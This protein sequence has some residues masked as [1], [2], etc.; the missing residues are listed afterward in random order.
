MKGEIEVS[1]IYKGVKV[2]EEVIPLSL[3]KAIQE[4]KKDLDR[5]LVSK[6]LYLYEMSCCLN[7]KIA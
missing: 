3:Y 4:R 7:N 5:G 2:G 1:V 6:E